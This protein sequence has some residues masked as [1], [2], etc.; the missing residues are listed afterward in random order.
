MGRSMM[1]LEMRTPVRSMPLTVN[2]DDF[3]KAIIDE[4]ILGKPAQRWQK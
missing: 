1:F 2:K 4:N 3:A